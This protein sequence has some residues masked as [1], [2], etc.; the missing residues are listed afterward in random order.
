M[1]GKHKHNYNVNPAPGQYDP[2]GAASQTKPKSTAAIIKEESGYSVPK[3]VAPDAG[4]V[5]GIEG[6]PESEV[7]MA[8]FMLYLALPVILFD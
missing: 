3:E 8:N 2:E 5:G 6:G 7:S 4:T 1:G